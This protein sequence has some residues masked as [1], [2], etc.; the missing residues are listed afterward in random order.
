M[1]NK[2]MPALVFLLGVLVGAVIALLYAPSSGEELREEL[3]RER[4][5]ALNELE[6]VSAELRDSVAETRGQLAVYAEQARSRGEAA[7][8]A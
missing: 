3:G 6:R 1:S 2:P 5:R 8:E 4:A 7:E